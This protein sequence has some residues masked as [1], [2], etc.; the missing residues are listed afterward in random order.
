MKQYDFKNR[1]LVSG[2]H[3][4]G[5]LFIAAGVLAII[6]SAIFQPDRSLEKPVYVGIAAIVFGAAILSTYTGTVIEFNERKAKDYFSF[7][8]YPFGEWK[9]LP[10]IKRIV[11]THVKKK[12]TNTPNG[13]SPTWSGTVHEFRAFLY[14]E[15]ATPIFSFVF[16]NKEQAIKTGKLLSENLHAEI[17]LT[18]L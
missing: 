5:V 18:D 14:S 16:S 6:G 12:V 13:I 2:P 8:G 4:L 1:Q 10:N 17:V 9:P 11:V 15:S 3:L 7:L